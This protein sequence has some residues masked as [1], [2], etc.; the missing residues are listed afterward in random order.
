MRL[1]VLLI[2][3]VVAGCNWG[4]ESPLT[5]IKDAELRKQNY[6]CQMAGELSAAE[7]QICKNIRRECDKR[8]SKGNYVC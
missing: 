4:R 5:N 7:I 1:S 2:L 6:R 3:V 8:A